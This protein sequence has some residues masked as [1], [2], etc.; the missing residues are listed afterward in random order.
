MKR[1][2]RVRALAAAVPFALA[3]CA[4]PPP[5]DCSGVYVLGD[6]VGAAAVA[7]GQHL[8]R[9]GPL[10]KAL[11]PPT[12]PRG[13]LEPDGSYAGARVFCTVPAARAAVAEMQAQGA[14]TPGREERVFQLEATWAN[15]VY[16]FR[17]GDYRLKHA[18]PVLR[19]AD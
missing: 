16:E 13:A 12:V 17:P 4:A 3:A 18:A 2:L 7:N 15:D 8:M 14:L 11:V 6:A 10:P 1:L 5:H 19:T 9:S